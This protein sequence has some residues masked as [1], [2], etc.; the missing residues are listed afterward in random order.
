M[1]AVGSSVPVVG[2]DVDIEAALLGESG[3]VFEEVGDKGVCAAVVNSR[4]GGGVVTRRWGGA[5][6]KT[7]QPKVT[8]K[9]PN[10]IASFSLM[11]DLLVTFLRLLKRGDYCTSHICRIKLV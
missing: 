3:V 9:Q 7:H 10:R 4:S 8:S 2:R 11:L 6:R 5:V 1:P